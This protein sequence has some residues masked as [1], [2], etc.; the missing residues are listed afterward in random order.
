MGAASASGHHGLELLEADEAIAVAVDAVD[1]AAA[2]GEGGALPDPAEDVGELVRRDGAAAVEVEDG[3]GEAEV[4]LER[5]GSS[6]EVDELGEGDESVAVNIGLAHHA[7]ELLLGGRLAAENLKDSGELRRR[8]L[9]VAIGIEFVEDSLQVAGVSSR[10]GS[11]AGGLRVGV[12][13]R[14]LGPVA[15]EK[16]SDL[17]HGERSRGSAGPKRTRET[18]LIR[19]DWIL[20]KGRRE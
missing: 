18:F 1:H 6:V 5:R 10:G 19:S 3:E 13:G 8:D 12:T 4:L 16:G 11:G 15:A 20:R 9:A 14:T 7:A 17:T 2:L